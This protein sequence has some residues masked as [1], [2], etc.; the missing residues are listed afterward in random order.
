[1]MN[2]E[3]QEKLIFLLQLLP[4]IGVWCLAIGITLFIVYLIM[5]AI[6]QSDVA[7]AAIG[8]SLVAIPI[9]WTLVGVF[10]YVFVGLRRG[11]R[12]GEESG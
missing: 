5:L 4:L 11:R 1:M 3:F 7:S 8:V 6:E 2:K 10:T 12:K 9:F